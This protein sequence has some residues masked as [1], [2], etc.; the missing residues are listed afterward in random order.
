MSIATRRA[1]AAFFSSE[2]VTHSRVN[3][4]PL[5]ANGAP[6]RRLI[7]ARHFPRP[8][9]NALM[10]NC[11]YSITH[12]PTPALYVNIRGGQQR[13]AIVMPLWRATFTAAHTARA[14]ETVPSAAQRRLW[15]CRRRGQ[16]HRGNGRRVARYSIAYVPRNMAEQS[17]HISQRSHRHDIG[18]LQRPGQGPRP[19]RTRQRIAPH[20]NCAPITLIT[21]PAAG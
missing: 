6:S 3:S 10:T 9:S 18:D 21:F 20:S 7:L 12:P 1:S 11:R 4:W 2:P 16:R 13:G 5:S 14:Q 8:I 17:P 19:I 15:Q